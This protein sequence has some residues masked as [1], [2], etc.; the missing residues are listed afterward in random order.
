M[1]LHF[2]ELAHIQIKRNGMIGL[3]RYKIGRLALQHNTGLLGVSE[4][5]WMQT[6][7]EKLRCSYLESVLLLWKAPWSQGHTS[8]RHT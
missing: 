6:L 1:N 4:I 8:D 2:A 5:D 7:L 3:P